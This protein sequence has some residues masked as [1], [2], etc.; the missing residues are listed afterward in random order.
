[1]FDAAGGREPSPATGP[2]SG[3]GAG[4][5][6]PAGRRPGRQAG[7]GRGAAVV[8]GR[9]HGA[10]VWATTSRWPTACS[11]EIADHGHRS[12]R[13]ALLPRVRIDQIA[14][15][16]QAGEPAAGREIVRRL[17]PAAVR[18]LARRMI[19]D[20]GFRTQAGRYVQPLCE[21]MIAPRPRA[22]VRS[23]SAS[24][25]PCSARTRAAPICCSTPRSTTAVEEGAPSLRRLLTCSASDRRAGRGPGRRWR[26]WRNSH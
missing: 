5:A 3:D 25:P 6:R 13:H 23:P 22:T 7:P 21:S 2:A 24:S 16:I 11:A 10:R 19:S 4:I 9:R 18:R 20:R 14:A 1:M 8:D 15:A 17:A 12:R 26:S